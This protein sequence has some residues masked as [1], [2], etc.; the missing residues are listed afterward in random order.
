MNIIP[1]CPFAHETSASRDKTFSII[2]RLNLVLTSVTARTYIIYRQPPSGQSRV[3]RVTQLRID[4][5]HCRESTG[6][7][8]R[9]SNPQDNPRNECSFFRI[10]NRPIFDAP[11][12]SHTHYWY[13]EC[14]RCC[15]CFHI[16]IHRSGLNHTQQYTYRRLPIRYVRT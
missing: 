11:L 16:I 4:G 2:L 5:V 13:V 15:G 12:F 7:V 10:H 1:L 8:H 14:V 9:A 3:Y 6:S